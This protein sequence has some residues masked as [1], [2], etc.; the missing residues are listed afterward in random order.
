MGPRARAQAEGDEEER[1]R[2]GDIRKDQKAG[3][4]ECSSAGEPRRALMETAGPLLWE[5]F[6]HAH[7]HT[8]IHAH[9]LTH[10]LIHTCTHTHTHSCTMTY[11]LTLTHIHTLPCTLTTLTV[12]G[13]FS[14]SHR[15]RP[16]QGGPVP[17]PPL[18]PGTP[19]GPVLESPARPL[20]G[21]VAAEPQRLWNAEHA[22]TC[23]HSAL[24]GI[25]CFP[26]APFF[27]LPRFNFKRDPKASLAPALGA[28]GKQQTG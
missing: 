15:G 27:L 21:R 17:R 4:L 20:P 12:A 10:T 7:T 5:V 3:G 9:T 16:S 28:W 18:Q 14:Q 13:S 2:G 6:T 8:L 1:R 25:C 26:L 23:G 22:D 11:T 19:T 24:P